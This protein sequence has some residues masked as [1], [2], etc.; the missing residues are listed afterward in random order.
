MSLDCWSKPGYPE[1]THTDMA[2]N[3]TQDLLAGKKSSLLSTYFFEE[4][5]SNYSVH[6]LIPLSLC[7]MFSLVSTAVFLAWLVA[8][9][10]PVLSSLTLVKKKVILC[11]SLWACTWFLRYRRLSTNSTNYPVC[12]KGRTEPFSCPILP[13]SGTQRHPLQSGKK[14]LRVIFQHTRNV[15]SSA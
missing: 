11:N 14:H 1:V 2:W 4:L 12:L 15:K 9:F 3:W 13:Y 8:Q 5:F 6:K 7:T 10:I